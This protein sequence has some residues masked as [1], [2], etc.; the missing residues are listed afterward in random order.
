MEALA[1]T[2][3]G[4]SFSGPLG[5]SRHNLETLH[6]KEKS[7]HLEI[8]CRGLPFVGNL[9]VLHLL[10]LVEGRQAGLLDRRDMDENVLAAALGLNEPI[11]LGRVEPLH[12]A[13]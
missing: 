1:N 12:R 2:R 8:L 7:F 6:S 5:R 4:A 10:A 3:A 11:T 13:T 9:F